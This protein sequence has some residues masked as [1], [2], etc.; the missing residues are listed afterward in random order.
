MGR[1]FHQLTG[2]QRDVLAATSIVERRTD[3]TIGLSIRETLESKGYEPIQG[4]RLYPALDELVSEGLLTKG[5]D[6]EDDRA[7]RYGVTE[8]GQRLLRELF[9][10]HDQAVSARDPEVTEA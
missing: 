2:F 4:G 5:P 10:F 8:E 7:N 3:R 9:E 6:P 1:E